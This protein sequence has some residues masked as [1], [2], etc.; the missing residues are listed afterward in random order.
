M[1]ITDLSLLRGFLAR[2][3]LDLVIGDATPMDGSCLLWAVKQ[4]M[5]HLSSLGLWSRVIPDNVEDLRSDVIQ[6][7]GRRRPRRQS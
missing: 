4:N 6:L 5:T 2:K 3:N 7:T 1:S